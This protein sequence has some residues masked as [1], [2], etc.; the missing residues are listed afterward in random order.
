MN[1]KLSMSHGRTQPSGR[2]SFE[3]GVMTMA[4]ACTILIIV[5]FAA[6]TLYH[7]G[8][9]P[10]QSEGDRLM[11]QPYG[12][13][14]YQICESIPPPLADKILD[15]G[16]FSSK[17]RGK[18]KQPPTVDDLF[19]L[20]IENGWSHHR[21]KRSN[22]LKKDPYSSVNPLINISRYIQPFI[23][24]AMVGLDIDMPSRVAILVENKLNFVGSMEWGSVTN[25]A[26]ASIKEVLKYEFINY[27]AVVGIDTNYTDSINSNCNDNLRVSDDDC[28]PDW[29]NYG[30]VEFFHTL[31]ADGL[32]DDANDACNHNGGKSWS[33]SNLNKESPKCNKGGIDTYNEYLGPLSSPEKSRRNRKP[34]N[35]AGKEAL[36]DDISNEGLE[37]D[38]ASDSE[39]DSDDDSESDSEEDDDDYKKESEDEY[40]NHSK[41]EVIF[42]LD[43]FE[44]L[45]QNNNVDTYKSMDDK[46]L[47]RKRYFDNILYAL[48]KD[49]IIVMGLGN[50]SAPGFWRDHEII[51]QFLNTY[52]FHV[53]F[54]YEE[55]NCG[56]LK[57]CSFLVMAR[58]ASIKYGWFQNPAEYDVRMHVNG[59]LK[60]QSGKS[61]NRF[62]GVSMARY[63]YPPKLWENHFCFKSSSSPYECGTVRG[64]NPKIEDFSADMFELKTS[65]LG[66]AAG[67]GLFAKVAIPEGSLIM[68][69]EASDSVHFPGTTLYVLEQILAKIP[70]AKALHEGLQHYYEGYGYSDYSTS[71]YEI[72]VD[73]GLTTFVNHGCKGTSN[74]GT[75]GIG[76]KI[77]FDDHASLNEET[78]M[79]LDADMVFKR[80]FESSSTY[81]P[82]LYR[83]VFTISGGLN[84]ALRA[85]KAG[86]EI[87][88]N[89]LLFGISSDF[90]ESILDVS[91][92]CLGALGMVSQVEVV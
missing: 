70:E 3:L 81:N 82:L 72:F 15:S 75:L 1:Y 61:L 78:A 19:S 89:Y 87:F 25:I 24:P 64:I 34:L 13:S 49:G 29:L 60:K 20:S 16:Q 35:S 46:V 7:T 27:V 23:H 32:C 91:S 44:V 92:Q 5:S 39:E 42:L 30:R 68:Q 17:N 14:I 37:N 67:R 54:A 59:I 2:C 22:R 79:S 73:S 56:L 52:P 55:N 71:D 28:S 50:P 45:S 10:M 12:Y 53:I 51:M 47:R 65:T 86:E 43:A 69:R 63:Q 74:I 66:K 41:Y 57:E 18:V 21:I 84:Y 26:E 88:T 4:L 8:V 9:M 77:T 31:L 33:R 58:T 62:D 38:S 40:S 36:I 85:I 83:K 6:G 90:E 76:Y 80:F 11:S 48:S